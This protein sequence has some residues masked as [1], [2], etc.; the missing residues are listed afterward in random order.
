MKLVL[1]LVLELVSV[2]GFAA[3]EGCSRIVTDNQTT[4]ICYQQNGTAIE[5][6]L[7]NGK[8]VSINKK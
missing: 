6:I 3:D 2:N 8:V 7:I 1:A 5:T 4:V